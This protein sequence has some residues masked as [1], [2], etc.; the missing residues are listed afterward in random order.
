MKLTGE[1]AGHDL[2]LFVEDL[3]EAAAMPA[4]DAGEQVLTVEELS[5]V[6]QGFDQDDFALAPA[7]AGQPAVRV[8]RPQAS[9]DFCRARSI[10]SWREHRTRSTRGRFQPTDGRQS[11]TKSSSALGAWPSAGGCPADVTRRCQENGRSVETIRYTLKAVR[12]RTSRSGDFP[13]NAGPLS[14]ETKQKIYQQYRRDVSVDALAKRYCRTKTSIYRII[15]EMRAERILELPLDYMSN[16]YFGR[17]SAEK[18]ILGPMPEAEVPAKKTRLPAGLPP[19]LASL[20][21]VPLLTREQEGYLF[22]K[23]NYLKYKAT[24]A[25]QAA[26]SGSRQEQRDGR[27]RAAVRPGRGRRRTRSCGPTCGWWF[28]SPSGTSG[29]ATTSSSWS[30]TAICR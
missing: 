27:D 12:P 30:A 22:R 16:P 24:R 14:D 9:R 2:R 21:E 8:R 19:Y 4:E 10:A 25:A 28:R 15:N 6:I 20:Y 23:F 5:Q 29:R 1:E 11:E 26:R 7:G 13:R 3:S 18:T 17:E